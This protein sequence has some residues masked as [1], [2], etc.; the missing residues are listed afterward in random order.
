MTDLFK[1][2]AFAITGGILALTV[3][4]YNASFGTLTAIIVG[5][6]VFFMGCDKLSAVVSELNTTIEQSGLDKEYIT[7]VIKVIGAAYI[8]QFGSEILRDSGEN[9][10]ALKTELAGKIVILY[11]IMPIVA[12]FLKICIEA[13]QKI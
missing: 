12:D 11:L 4:H 13:A 9:A 6:F 2:V 10:I 8:T 7:V 1:I 5:I 3:R